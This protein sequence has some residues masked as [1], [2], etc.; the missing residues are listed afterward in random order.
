MVGG[1]L[2]LWQDQALQRHDRGQ[3]GQGARAGAS[4][5]GFERQPCSH[6]KQL[7]ELDLEGLSV[8]DCEILDKLLKARCS[9]FSL[10]I[11]EM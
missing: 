11:C 6:D 5:P 1:P 4:L 2:P 10:L 8:T 7:K 3:R 9:S